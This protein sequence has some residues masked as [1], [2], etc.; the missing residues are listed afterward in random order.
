M[1]I[2]SLQ[3]LRHSSL[4]DALEDL[5]EHEV[6]GVR[7][8]RLA[9]G[10][11][12]ERE[13]GDR[14]DEPLRRNHGSR[15]ARHGARPRLVLHVFRDAARVVEQMPDADPPAGAEPSRQ[16]AVD[17]VVELDL[18]LGDE[19]H[20]HRR[21]EG[22]GHAPDPEPVLR[23][24]PPAADLR[25]SRGDDGALAVLLDERDHGGDLGRGDEPVGVP[26]ELGLGRRAGSDEQGA[27]ESESCDQPH[28]SYTR[29]G[30]SALQGYVRLA[31][32]V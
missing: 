2:R 5:A 29:R 20:D 11:V 25:V 15:V 19:L 26:L 17:S 3:Q 18:A 1:K 23:T 9:T 8:G 14:R 4:G 6:V 13:L 12:L 32:R 24:S 31:R 27:G 22:L 30:R 28:V 7:V 21:D 16:I 10:P